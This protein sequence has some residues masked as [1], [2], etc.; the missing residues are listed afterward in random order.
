MIYVKT[1][2]AIGPWEEPIWWK[3]IIINILTFL[4]P[5]AN[6]DF[7]HLYKNV[8]LWWLELDE[9]NY[10]QREIGFDENN[11]LLVAAPIGNNYGFFTDSGE[12][13]ESS[14][15]ELI[16]QYQFINAWEEF[17]NKYDHKE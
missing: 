16:E 13:I 7:D 11:T 8:R 14:D 6:P 15:Y 1:T 3:K 9:N 4:I 12:S 17:S 10:P 2:L 5:K